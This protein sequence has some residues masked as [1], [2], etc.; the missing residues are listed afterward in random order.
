MGHSGTCTSNLE[1]TEGAVTS[2]PQA[3]YKV[4][5]TVTVEC[6]PD[7]E[8]NSQLQNNVLTCE[9]TGLWS[10]NDFD[11]ICIKSMWKQVTKTKLN[12]VFF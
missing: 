11:N 10:F 3:I 5:D 9:T 8:M 7:F 1:I 4:G 6:N 12:G 2:T